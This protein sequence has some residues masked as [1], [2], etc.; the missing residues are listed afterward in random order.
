MCHFF[1]HVDLVFIIE[2]MATLKGQGLYIHKYIYKGL[3]ILSRYC[4][5]Q[6]SEFQSAME[7]SSVDIDIEVSIAHRN[8]ES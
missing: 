4:S 5:C 8:S 1:L 7:T 3:R 2:M 6:D